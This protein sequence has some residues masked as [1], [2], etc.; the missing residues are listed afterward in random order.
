MLQSHYDHMGFIATQLPLADTV[1]D[2]WRMTFDWKVATIV[3]L[4]D[5]PPDQVGQEFFILLN[6]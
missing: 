2:F 3:Q 6:M 4:I 5:G 1:L